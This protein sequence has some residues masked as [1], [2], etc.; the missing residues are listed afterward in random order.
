MSVYPRQEITIELLSLG[1]E[2]SGE[3]PMLLHWEE[4]VSDPRARKSQIAIEYSYRLRDQNP[5]TWVF[6]VHA[7]STARFEQG[8][9]EI[10]N[11]LELPGREDVKNDTLQLVYEGLRSEANGRWLIILDNADD[12]T[13]LFG[14]VTDSP[15]QDH[16]MANGIAPLS[17]FIP[18]TPHGSVLVTSR[19]QLAAFKLVGKRHNLIEVNP[20]NERDALEMLKARI[21][22]DRSTERDAK[23]LLHDLGYIPLAISQAAAYINVRT[24][25]MTVAKYLAIFWENEANRMKLLNEDSGDLRR[26]PGVPNAVITTWQISFDQIGNDRPSATELLSLMSVLDP[27]GIP[28]FLLSRGCNSVLEFEDALAP[29]IDFSLIT[30]EA[31]RKAFDMHPLVQLATR[32]WLTLRGGLEKWQRESVRI[33][34]ETF[35]DGEH[36]HWTACEALEPHAQ[37]VLGYNSHDPSCRLEQARI[38]HNSGWYAWA[39][40][41]YVTAKGRIEEA[42]KTRAALLGPDGPG[43]LASL[44]LLATVLSDQGKY[45]VA[46]EIYRQTLTLRETVLGKEHPSTLTSMNNL[47]EALSDQGKYEEAEEMHRR[48][49]TLCETVLGKEHPSTL[50]SMNNLAMA[51]GH[52]G[53]Y[54]EAEEMHRRTLTLSETVLGKE[55]PYTLTSMNNLATVLS[56]QGKYDEA[57][58]MHR[59]TLTLCEPV[60]GKEHPSTLTSMNNLAEALSDQGKRDEAEEM[61]RRTLTLKETVLGKEH[62]STLT[63]MNNLAMVLSYQGKYEEAEEMHRWTLTLSETVLGKEHPSTLTSMNNLAMVLSHQGKYEEA[64][65][66][67]RRTLTLSETVLGKEHPDTLTSMDNLAGVLSDQGKCEEAEEMHRRTLMLR[68]AVLGKEHPD[69]LIS[70]NNL[71]GVLSDQGK[72]EEAEE[73]YRRTLT[74]RKTILGAEHP[75]T[76]SSRNSLAAVLSS[77][78]K[79]GAVA[80]LY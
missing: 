63:S 25:R 31:S 79:I 9:R 28:E 54:E 33:I 48:T 51:L 8:Y 74:L 30:T 35:P 7:N 71:A 62:P 43:T 80:E 21:S 65:E 38:L 73:M 45:E 69:T 36:A 52:Q 76:L 15:S 49:L 16:G 20:M 5:Q 27:R 11:M 23:R 44:G 57:E 39:R 34:S 42:L 60:L 26:D 10:A 72:R 78:G 47:A 6:W 61:H 41:N 2:E 12:E 64:E 1:S 19:N 4:N 37:T 29:L 24:M 22:V 17:R 58:E 77:Q 32:K 13:F 70:M 50:T 59:R 53:K 3:T 18:Q 67:H 66:M 56:D 68:E 55:H 40:G 14:Q 75:H 46:E